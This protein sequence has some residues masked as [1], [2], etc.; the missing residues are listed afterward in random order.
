M[1]SFLRSTLR[2]AA[3]RALHTQPAASPASTPNALELIRSQP[4]QYIV[5]SV[6]GQKY[7]LSP[8]DLLT[9]PR[10]NDVKVGDVLKLS[11]IHEIGSREYTVRGSPIIPLEHVNVEATVV[12]HTKGP[13]QFIVKMKRRKGYKRTVQHKQTYTRLRIGPIHIPY[14][15]TASSS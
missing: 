8:R 15:S 7:I 14:S 2:T 9:V 1:A 4:S 13:M 5:A 6:A 3:S 12:E 10:L 11:N